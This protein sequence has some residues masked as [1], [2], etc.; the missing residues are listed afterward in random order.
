MERL[1]INDLLGKYQDQVLQLRFQFLIFPNPAKIGV[2]FQNMKM[3]I[4]SF[5]LILILYTQPEIFGQNPVAAV[6]QEI[7]V[8]LNIKTVFLYN[9]EESDGCL[10]ARFIA[11]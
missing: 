2:V 11:C 10:Q 8:K 7:A 3:R 9:P 4:N 1:L 6:G 5:L